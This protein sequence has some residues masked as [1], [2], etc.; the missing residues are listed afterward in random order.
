M[1]QYKSQNISIIM[2]NLNSKV[3]KKRGG[4]IAS[5]DQ[6][7]PPPHPIMSI[8]EMGPVVHGSGPEETQECREHIKNMSKNVYFTVV[9]ILM[10]RP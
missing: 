3:E 5:S 6:K 2:E 1:N 8:E 10:L 9:K 7:P 4:E